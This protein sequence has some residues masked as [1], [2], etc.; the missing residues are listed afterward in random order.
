MFLGAGCAQQTSIGTSLAVG[1]D[2]EALPTDVAVFQLT[3]V[4]LL[5]LIHHFIRKS[6]VIVIRLPDPALLAAGELLALLDLLNGL[7]SLAF[8]GEG[9]RLK[10]RL[11]VLNWIRRFVCSGLTLG[12]EQALFIVITNLLS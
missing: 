1:S 4:W 5:F 11:I 8:L 2:G 6:V 9:F 12:L 7:L 10:F 3:K